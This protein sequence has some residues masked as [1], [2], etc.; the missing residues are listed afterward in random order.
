MRM[1][2]VRHQTE[3]VVA[4]EAEEKN[5][6]K[7]N[8]ESSQRDELL[9]RTHTFLEVV[10]TTIQQL[11]IQGVD[12]SLCIEHFFD[13][14]ILNLFFFKQAKPLSSLSNS[15]FHETNIKRLF[16]LDEFTLQIPELDLKPE[17]EVLC[18]NPEIVEKLEQCVMNWQTHIT[19]VIEEQRDKKPQVC[20]FSLF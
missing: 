20:Q 15:S 11:Q 16:V 5:S 12:L 1:I 2:Q 8:G 4:S 9:T 10:N 7:S 19:I 18:S 14:S 17:V 13:I 6:G 3:A